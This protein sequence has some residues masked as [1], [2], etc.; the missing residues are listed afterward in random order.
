MV[1]NAILLFAVLANLDENRLNRRLGLYV[2]DVKYNNEDWSYCSLDR[3][4]WVVFSVFRAGYVH[5][6][7][8]TILFDTYLGI[9]FLYIHISRS[10][11][12]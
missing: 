11:E 5:S 8:E 9:G 1:A 3:S 6:T 7:S 12:P 2:P 4:N 10:V